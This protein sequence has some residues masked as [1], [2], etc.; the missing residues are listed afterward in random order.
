MAKQRHLSNA[1][2]KEAVVD[3]RVAPAEGIRAEVFG[4]LKGRLANEYPTA[5]ERRALQAEFLVGPGASTSSARDL[6]LLG[7]FFKSANGQR[8]AQFRIDGFTLNYLRPYSNWEDIRNE[9]LRLWP[10]YCEAAAPKGVVRLATR[11]IN[12][13]PGFSSVH[14][15]PLNFTSPPHLPEKLTDSLKVFFQRYLVVEE[16]SGNQAYIT[17]GSEPAPGLG[18]FAVAFDVDA[19]RA[20]YWSCDEGEIRPILDSLRNFKNQ[21]FFGSV[22][23]R[24]LEP[25]E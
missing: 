4:Q 16:E 10:M 3:F 15:L 6:G 23:D 9:A 17:L 20:G 2:I 24:L 25:Y 7:F 5:N 14:D 1:P 11:Y 19:F 22:T 18:G 13:L 12:Y 21:I 8:I